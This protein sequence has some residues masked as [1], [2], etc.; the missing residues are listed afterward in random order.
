MELGLA[1]I[2]PELI[3]SR[4][5]E[6]PQLPSQMPW[7]SRLKFANRGTPCGELGVNVKTARRAGLYITSVKRSTTQRK[8]LRLR[9]CGFAKKYN[10]SEDVCHATVLMMRKK[11]SFNLAWLYTRLT[12]Y[13]ALARCASST[14]WFIRESLAGTW[15]HRHSFDGV[16]KTWHCKQ[17]G[18]S[19]SGWR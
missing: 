5:F 4:C 6:I 19:R 2:H 8:L 10:E 14:N 11:T 13:Q 16:L 18:R 12:C 15:K 9:R 3:K 17:V 7:I 1:N